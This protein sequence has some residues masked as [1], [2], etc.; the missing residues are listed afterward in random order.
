MFKLLPRSE[1]VW[2]MALSLPPNLSVSIPSRAEWIAPITILTSPLHFVAG[3][4]P[5]TEENTKQWTEH[6]RDLAELAYVPKTL[7]E[8]DAKVSSWCG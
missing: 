2:S 8:L 4:C 1:E 6:Q 7:D 5:V 3:K